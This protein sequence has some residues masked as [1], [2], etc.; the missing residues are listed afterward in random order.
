MKSLTYREF[1]FS[2][3]LVKTVKIAT[4]GFRK[5]FSSCIF[6]AK[7][8]LLHSVLNYQSTHGLT[9]FQCSVKGSDFCPCAYRTWKG[10]AAF[11]TRLQFH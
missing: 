7:F 1:E 9:S 2:K 5:L 11:P 10:L 6:F 3:S 4:G 8:M